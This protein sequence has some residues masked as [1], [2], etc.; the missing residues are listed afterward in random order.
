MSGM[1]R[2]TVLHSECSLME[3]DQVN[4]NIRTP[5]RTIDRAGTVKRGLGVQIPSPAL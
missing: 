1:G 2:G 3:S 4:G 5:M